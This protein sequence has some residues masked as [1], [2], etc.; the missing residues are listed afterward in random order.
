V[1]LLIQHAGL[2]GYRTMIADDCRLSR[3]MYDTVAAHPDFEAVTQGL[4]IA[5]FRYL[6]H[7]LRARVGEP[8]IESYLNDLNSAILS[9]LQENGDLFVSNA[10]LSGRYVLR[11]CIT[12]WRTKEEDVLAVPSLV[13][14]IGDKLHGHMKKQILVGR[15]E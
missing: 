9:H 7:E 5:T 10:V 15:N 4:S 13:G 2:D 12:N 3:L 8:G 11:A 1:W 6:P 14:T